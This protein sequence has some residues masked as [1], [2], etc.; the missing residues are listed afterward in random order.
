MRFILHT[1]LGAALT[2][3]AAC[4]DSP[5]GVQD[6]AALARAEARWHANGSANYQ[7]ESRN[8]CFCPR[9]VMEWATVIV[10]DDTV[11][12]VTLL[13]GSPLATALWSAHP[14]IRDRFA[15]IRDRPAYA[16]DLIIT[17]DRKTGYPQRIQ[18]LPEQNVA[19]GGYTL[20]ARHLVIDPAP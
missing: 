14:P 6:F 11:A 17:Y 18:L 4:T 16:R 2:A 20:Q 9:E 19:D 13:D 3:L 8:L 5:L 7:F 1:A 10:R 15:Q 12:A